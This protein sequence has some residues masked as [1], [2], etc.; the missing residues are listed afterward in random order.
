MTRNQVLCTLRPEALVY[1]E[2]KQRNTSLCSDVFHHPE[3]GSRPGFTPADTSHRYGLVSFK[4]GP[5]TNCKWPAAL[6]E[7]PGCA[8]SLPTKP[9]SRGALQAASMSICHVV[10]FA[11]KSFG[12]ELTQASRAPTGSTL[13]HASGLP[14]VIRCETMKPKWDF[15]NEVSDNSKSQTL[16]V[17]ISFSI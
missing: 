3:A 17:P 14:G 6:K 12:D 9:H 13:V 8:S 11:H 4:G 7:S 2:T 1:G 16:K 5:D 10:I 15:V